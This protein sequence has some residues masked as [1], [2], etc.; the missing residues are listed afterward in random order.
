MSDPVPVLYIRGCNRSGSIVL[1]QNLGWI[2]S[3]VD[4]GELWRRTVADML[5]GLSRETSAAL[6]AN[7]T[8]RIRFSTLSRARLSVG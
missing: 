5:A 6:A 7:S 2:P 1:A 8:A 3:L 4:F